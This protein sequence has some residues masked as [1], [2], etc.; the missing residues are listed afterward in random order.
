MCDK[1][2]HRLIGQ[3]KNTLYADARFI[4]TLA[5]CVLFNKPSLNAASIHRLG[6]KNAEYEITIK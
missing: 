1:T 3:P 4:F 2:K 6:N 5:T